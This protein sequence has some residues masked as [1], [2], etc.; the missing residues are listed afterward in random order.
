[1]YPLHNNQQQLIE[2]YLLN[3]LTPIEQA[4]FDQLLAT[5]KTHC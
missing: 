5:N 1:M 2:K 4:D 3:D